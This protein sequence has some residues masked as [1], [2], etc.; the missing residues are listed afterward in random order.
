VLYLHIE[1]SD[2]ASATGDGTGAAKV[3]KLGTLTLDLARDWLARTGHVTVRPVLDM[4]RADTVDTH[5]PPAWMREQVELRDPHCVFPGCGVDA[6][7]CD[8]DHLVP[9]LP[10]DEGGPPGQT[11][12]PNLAPLCR[13]HH[14]TKTF[15]GW[16][17]RRVPDPWS[18]TGDGPAGPRS[19]TYEW[20]SPNGRTF[21][22]TTGPR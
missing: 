16:T 22:V 3:E 11:S 20:T 5:D 7:D 8:L 12:A 17:Y 18:S 6:R 13:R 19:T 2:L 10:M 15:G 4:A 14:R 9:Y 21:R 1:A